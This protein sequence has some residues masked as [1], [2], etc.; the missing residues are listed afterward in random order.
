MILALI[1]LF[2]LFAPTAPP[3]A[4]TFDDA[5]QV[6]W[7][8]DLEDALQ[9]SRLANRPLLVAV[10]AD[11][12]SASELIVRERYRDPAWV[13]RTR[14]FVCVIA[15]YFRHT[16]RDYDDDGARIPCPRFGEITCGEHMALEPA[17]H[18]RFMKGVKIELF[19]ETTERISPRHV[20]VN[21]DGRVVFDKYLLFELGE[22]DR[23]LAG[24]AAHWPPIEASVS[25]SSLGSDAL[26]CF[27]VRQRSR[28]RN[29][30]L[31]AG[32]GA[33]G[34]VALRAAFDP[35][36]PHS[37]GALGIVRR[38]GPELEGADLASELF[39]W[40][41]P[42]GDLDA[43]RT[44]LREQVVRDGADRARLLGAFGVLGASRPAD[45]TLFRSFAA[46]GDPDELEAARSTL[47]RVEGDALARELGASE[48]PIG[49]F[50]LDEFERSLRGEEVVA[51]RATRPQA[52]FPSAAECEE[53]LLEAESRLEQSPQDAELHR[54]VGTAALGLARR[55]MESRGSG[56]DALLQDANRSL[57]LACAARPDDVELLL[58]RAR[59]A[60]Y[61]SNFDE[62]ERLALTAL[63]VA[64][65]SDNGFDPRNAEALRWLGDACARRL[66]E[67]SGGPAFDEVLA[68]ARGGAAL[69]LA[70][71]AADSDATDWL[72]LASYFGALGRSRERVEFAY[73]GLR[74]FPASTE[75]RNELASACW[76]RGRPERYVELSEQLADE[77]PEWA[78]SQWYVGYARVLAAEWAR[79]GEDADGAIAHYQLAERS[80]A[81]AQRLAPEFGD[82]CGHYLGMCAAGRGF[83]HL[84]A[85]RREEA[86]RCAVELAR[87]RPAAVSQRDG[88]EREGVDLVDGVLETRASGPTPVDSAAWLDQLLDAD[89]GD[90]FWPRSIADAELREAIRSYQRER[91]ELGD[92][93][94][95]RG[96]GAAR[97]ARE[98]AAS[99]ATD[100]ALAQLLV[101]FAERVEE[102]GGDDAVRRRALERVGEAAQVLG[103]GPLPSSVTDGEL[104]AFVAR[105]RSQL[106]AARPT[107]RPGR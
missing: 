86:A 54:L 22:L 72:S 47:P 10:N 44:W 79:R 9:L 96:I 51:S 8:R 57:A 41:A 31:W 68:I 15:S 62:Q 84:L 2:S 78:E 61:L 34:L 12:E 52:P 69:A 56:V 46:L 35:N 37:L 19:G 11:G 82:S 32:T 29:E 73:E 25:P 23:A 4:P 40:T 28:L 33:R 24:E 6:L 21:P 49:G 102:H 66:G 27:D 42:A 67:R 93:Q 75:L 81:R 87:L 105:L 92:R 38:L 3:Q 89:P 98:I 63:S 103:E 104:K 76:A 74:R 65:A 55:R 94:I 53:A 88:L 106:G 64:P 1:A 36:A 13:A 39:R 91:L 107:F 48:L 85:N 18:E 70:T 20:L 5:R 60:N 80:F 71:R 95:E 16:P 77:Q 83:A 43:A 97:R 14:S 45:R 90:V 30:D 59:V 100:R 7:Q 101:V 58:Q 17:T 99:E 50:A 26:W